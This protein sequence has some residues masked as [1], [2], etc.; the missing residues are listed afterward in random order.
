MADPMATDLVAH[1]AARAADRR[2]FLA[3]AI[4][5]FQGFRQLD[6]GGLAQYLGC[7]VDTLTL[8]RLCRRPDVEAQHLQQDVSRI[9]E[10]FG[11]DPIALMRLLR[12]VATVEAMRDPHEGARSAGFLM[13]ARDKRRKRRRGDK[14]G[15]R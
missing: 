15:V 3:S 11:V 7:P 12:E 14:D 1:G 5:A 8:L 2:F 6:D 10:R 4:A 13:A 9:S